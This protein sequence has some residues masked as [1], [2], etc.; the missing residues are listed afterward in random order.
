[1]YKQHYFIR[2]PGILP[3]ERKDIRMKRVRFY[4]QDRIRDIFVNY[5]RA[6]NN[7]KEISESLVGIDSRLLFLANEQYR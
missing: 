1:M 5:F 4:T 6:V 3:L 7:R 2:N